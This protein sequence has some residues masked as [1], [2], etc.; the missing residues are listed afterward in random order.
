MNLCLNPSLMIVIETLIV[1]NDSQ[2]GCPFSA[3]HTEVNFYFQMQHLIQES[4]DFWK[5]NKTNFNVKQDLIHLIML[6]FT[7]SSIS[8]ITVFSSSLSY[9]CNSVFTSPF[10][11]SET[12][13]V[14]GGTEYKIKC[15]TKMMKCNK[16]M[17]KC[18]RKLRQLNN[19]FD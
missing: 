2:N 9:L 18:K 17:M 11:L 8:S 10:V 13:E 6:I 1:Q 19:L 14:E 4:M 12:Q 3:Y 15:K 7:S 16:K 5:K